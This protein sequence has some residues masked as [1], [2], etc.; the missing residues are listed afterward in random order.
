MCI[1]R[2][3]VDRLARNTSRSKALTKTVIT[4]LTAKRTMN[5]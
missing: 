4:T 2:N 3:A 1:L 5:N